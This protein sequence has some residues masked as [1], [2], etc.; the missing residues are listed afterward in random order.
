V[1]FYFGPGLYWGWPYFYGWPYYGYSYGYPY[2]YDYAYPNYT[3][4]YPAQPEYYVEP[5]PQGASSATTQTYWY[6]CTEPKGYYPYVTNCT[7][8]WLRV[9]PPDAAGPQSPSGTQAPTG[10]PIAPAQAK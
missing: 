10:A 1:G 2:V 6:Y 9:L 8:P 5:A 4:A 3:Y 7:Q